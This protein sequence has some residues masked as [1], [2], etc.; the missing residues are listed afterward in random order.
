MPLFQSLSIKHKLTWIIMLTSSAVLLLACT[1]FVT[2]DQIIFRRTVRSDVQ[3]LAKIIGAH[4][5]ATLEFKSQPMGQEF[6]STLA[7]RK[8]I[9]SACFYLADDT[10]LAQYARPGQ[11][12][13]PPPRKPE[14]IGL[15][16]QKGYLV[17]YEPV[18]YR[19]DRVGTLYLQYF[20][21]SMGRLQT[22]SE[23][24]AVILVGAVLV[25]WLIS[26]RLQR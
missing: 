21:E 15:H 17:V 24:V 12:V 13:P 18:V 22:F 8:Q 20:D 1:A 23:V 6:L 19:G 10:I 3:T 14:S 4:S 25:V 9:V 7:A 11:R 26:F 16:F 5:G 2:Y